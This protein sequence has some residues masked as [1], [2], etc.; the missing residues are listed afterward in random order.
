MAT[1]VQAPQIETKT[2]KPILRNGDPNELNLR[3]NNSHYL[4]KQ[5]CLFKNNHAIAY[6]P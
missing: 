6:Y 3:Q 2:Q 1:G 4:Q 5:R